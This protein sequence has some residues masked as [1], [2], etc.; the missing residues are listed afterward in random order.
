MTIIAKKN[1]PQLQLLQK[2]TE[3]KRIIINKIKT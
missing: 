2:L 3:E 1:V